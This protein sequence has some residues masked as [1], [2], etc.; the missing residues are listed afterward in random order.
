MLAAWV[1]P[2]RCEGYDRELDVLC[3]R[4]IDAIQSGIREKEDER[5]CFEKAARKDHAECLKRATFGKKNFA[6][7]EN[8]ERYLEPA[9]NVLRKRKEYDDCL[10][11]DEMTDPG[12]LCRLKIFSLLPFSPF[13]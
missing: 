8:I 13:S 10:G 4:D 2:K 6:D 7:T 11:F 12:V 3:G 5:K 9:S 1:D